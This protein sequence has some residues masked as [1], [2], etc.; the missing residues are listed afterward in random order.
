MQCNICGANAYYVCGQSGR[1]VCAKHARIEVVS[2]LSFGSSDNLSVREITPE[3]AASVQRMMEYFNGGTQIS[4]FE[5]DY[6]TLALPGFVAS[7]GKQDA[8]VLIYSLEPAGM[9]LVK[10]EVLPGH[11]GLGVGKALLAAALEKAAS[12]GAGNIVTAVSNDD[13][14]AVYFYQN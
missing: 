5:R 14:S 7:T 1:P 10:M 4:F 11:Q 8:G 9:V 13:L 12:S 3:D 6:Y 2:R